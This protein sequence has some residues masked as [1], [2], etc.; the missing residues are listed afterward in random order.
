MIPVSE[1]VT[2]AADLDNASR[3]YGAERCCLLPYVG[4][5]CAA[6]WDNSTNVLFVPNGAFFA[7]IAL[8]AIRFCALRKIRKNCAGC[9][10]RIDAFASKPAYLSPVLAFEI[11]LFME[12]K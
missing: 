12:E 6:F 1:R 7:R 3:A 11:I 5:I 10:A 4:G 8:M 9:S 2:K